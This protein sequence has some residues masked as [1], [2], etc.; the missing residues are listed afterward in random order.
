MN[1]SL[2]VPLVCQ[3]R[4]LWTVGRHCDEMEGRGRRRLLLFFEGEYLCV[5]GPAVVLPDDADI[6]K[7]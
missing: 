4:R 3:G 2:C 6:L 1:P 7:F 5:L